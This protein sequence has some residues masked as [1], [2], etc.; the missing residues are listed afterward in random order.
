MADHLVSPALIQRVLRAPLDAREVCLGVDRDT[1]RLFDRDDATKVRVEQ[2]L[3]GRIGKQLPDWN[4]VDTGVFLATPALFDALEHATNRGRHALS[5]GIEALAEG[6]HARAVDVTGEPWI[7]VDTPESFREARR[8][9]LRSL[10]KSGDDGYIAAHLKPPP[11]CTALCA[12]RAYAHHADPAQRDQFLDRARRGSLFHP[13]S[14]LDGGGR[15]LCLCNS[16]RWST[17]AMAR[18][19]AFDI[20]P[21]LAGR[22]STRCWTGTRTVAVVVALTLGYAAGHSGALP[23]LGGFAASTGFLLASY[24]TKGVR[25]PSRHCLSQRLARAVEAPGPAGV[26]DLSAVDC[27]VT[28]STPWSRSGSSPM[29]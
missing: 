1:V 16:P 25:P 18:S 17:D 8:R 12:A 3:I 19:R 13:R 11:V 22:G 21:P 15:G 10:G 5:H 28:L 4:A 29:A 2:G 23:W 27:S 7:D 26:R 24:S 9:L 14:L 6:G 20:W